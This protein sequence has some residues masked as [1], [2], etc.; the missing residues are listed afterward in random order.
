MV[1]VYMIYSV[2][3]LENERHSD[4]ANVSGAND[5]REGELKTLDDHDEYGAS[6]PI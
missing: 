1:A 5:N 4:S 2:P 3:A 6:I